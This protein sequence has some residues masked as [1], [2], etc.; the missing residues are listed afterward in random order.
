MTSLSFLGG[1]RTVTGSDHLARGA[2]SI[3]VL[4]AYRRVRARVVRMDLSAHADQ[5][6]LVAWL[7]TASPPPETVFV[8]HG[9]EPASWALADRLDAEQA[10]LAVVPRPDERISL[11]RY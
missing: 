2:K 6:D 9:E 8:V 7:A 11:D 5:D 4:G 3:K 1:T 10:L